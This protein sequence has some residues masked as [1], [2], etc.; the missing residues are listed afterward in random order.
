MDLF[1]DLTGSAPR[2]LRFRAR[3]D[4]SGPLNPIGVASED[5]RRWIEAR[6][7]RP[8]GHWRELGAAEYARSFAVAR[9]SGQDIID[10]LYFAFYDV[11]SAGGTE[12][13]FEA[14]VLP[15]L[16]AKGWLQGE[17][18]ASVPTRVRLIYDTNLRLAR[19]SGQWDRY[20]SARS[21]L[22]YLRGVTGRD[23][24]VR[25]PPKSASDHNAWE[26][27][28]LPIDHPFWTRWFPP[29]GFRCRCSVIQMTRSQLARFKGGITSER[30][31]A[32]REARL[33]EPIFLP[34]PRGI[35]EQVASMAAATNEARTPGARSISPA[36]IVQ[37]GASLWDG[38]LANESLALLDEA[39]AKLFGIAA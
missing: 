24:R 7:P 27:I 34:P 19:A 35:E 32:D 38:I 26:G 11:V 18:G 17:G 2:L 22:P 12:V 20:W 39:I 4:L 33:G 13:D 16:Q 23:D 14:A 25:H 15:T 36:L 5:I 29:L 1:P 9:T 31:L 6:D 3:E 21:G 37:A 10:D 30:T 8:V 28:I